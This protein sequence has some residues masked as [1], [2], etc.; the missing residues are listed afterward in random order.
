MSNAEMLF[1]EKN[2]MIKLPCN[3]KKIKA[4]KDKKLIGRITKIT[5]ISLMLW[6]KLAQ[7]KSKV[8]KYEQE[9]HCAVNNNSK[10]I[11]GFVIFFVYVF[12]VNI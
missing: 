7:S 6:K 12:H 10:V 3:L 2:E 8:N 11:P 5:F 4:K 1:E 9:L